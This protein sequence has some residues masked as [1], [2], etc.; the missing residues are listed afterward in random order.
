[1]DEEI[2]LDKHSCTVGDLLDFIEKH[3]IS[4]DSKILLERVHDMYFDGCDIA[5]I[6][7]QLA[8]STYGPLPEGSKSTPWKSFKKPNWVGES[9]YTVAWS[10]AYYPDSKHLF[11]DCHY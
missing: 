5:G 3:K 10:P 8:D 6:T 4:R 9:E 2:D 1:M 7:G 11:I